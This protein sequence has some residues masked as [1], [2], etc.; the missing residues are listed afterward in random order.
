MVLCIISP[1]T[2]DVQSVLVRMN[3]AEMTLDVL[4]MYVSG[5]RARGCVFVL[6][7]TCGDCTF[8]ITRESELVTNRYQCQEGL[9]DIT[10]SFYDWEEDGSR[11]TLAIPPQL[12]N[13]GNFV[14]GCAQ[15]GFW[16][17]LASSNA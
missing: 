16:H 5:T 17:H 13:T 8:N 11:G 12:V 7:G 9:E 10:Y 3:S 6:N 15:K 2:T 14:L 1:D 4:C